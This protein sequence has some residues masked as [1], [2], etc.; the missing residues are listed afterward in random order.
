[1][2]YDFSPIIEYVGISA[3]YSNAVLL[4]ILPHVSDFAKTLHLPMPVPVIPEH[5]ERFSCSNHR[6]EVGGGMMLTN[7]AGFS[8]TRGHLDSFA[9]PH[10]YFQLQNPDSIPKFY[11]PL[12]MNEQEAIQLARD[13]ITNLGY[14]LESVFAEQEPKVTPPERIGTNVVP[15]FLIQWVDPRSGFPQTE[16]E[17]NGNRKMV[18]AM[19][20]PNRNLD[21]PP[22]K[23]DVQPAKLQKGDVGWWTTQPLI[24]PAYGYRLLPIVLKAVDEYGK[25]LNLPIPRYLT[26]NHVKRFYCED[27]G[28]WPASELELTNG[29]RFIYRNSM[30][31]GFYRPDNLFNSDQ[32]P[33]RIKE[34][35]GKWNM[36]EAEAIELVQRNLARLNYPTNL[37]NMDFMPQ[38][39]KPAVADIP[40]FSFWWFY[41]NE[42]HTDLQSKVEAEVDAD[43]RE[44]K[45]LYYDHKAFWNKPPPIDVPISLSV[46][47]ETKARAPRTSSQPNSFPKAPARPF[48]PV[49]PSEKR[50]GG[51]SP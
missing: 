19:R 10:S 17:I 5:V 21:R 3:Q 22:P 51:S 47:T 38:V 18:E 24:N 50:G 27:N 2:I 42:A 23:I 4:A 12:R 43:K 9:G 8:F 28:G 31:N 33:I 41:E 45:S 48:I 39:Q 32:R 1:M 49:I 35:V 6:G 16:V 15:H 13:T 29:W 40:R 34:F 20:L 30:V 11:G 14:S 25:S 37:V 26:T 36:T 7:G 44:L 46:P